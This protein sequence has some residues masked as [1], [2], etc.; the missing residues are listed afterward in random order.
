MYPCFIKH[1]EYDEEPAARVS[2]DEEYLAQLIGWFGE[3]GQAEF[4]RRMKTTPEAAEE[5]KEELWA[6]LTERGIKFDKRW[7]IAK[8]KEALE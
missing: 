8:L 3:E 4:D 6:E 5:S 1:K 7:S 2:S